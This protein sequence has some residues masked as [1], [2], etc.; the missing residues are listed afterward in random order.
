MTDPKLPL[1]ASWDEARALSRYPVHEARERAIRIL[2]DA[3]AYDAI[4]EVEFERRLGRLSAAGSAPAIGAIVEGL[5]AMGTAEG[6]SSRRMLPTPRSKI[7]GFMS[8]VHRTGPWLVPEALFIRAVMCN[9][10][11]DLRYA[12][13]QSP[14]TIDVTAVIASV[15]LLVSPGLAVEFDMQPILASVGSDAD[16]GMLGGHASAHVRIVGNAVMADVRVRVA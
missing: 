7:A 14:C 15:S 13:I 8:D 4:T 1:P 2:T 5:P 11:I 16:G 12:V 9:M 3:Y 10:T 6:R